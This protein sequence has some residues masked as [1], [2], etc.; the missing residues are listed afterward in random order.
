M[1]RRFGE[2]SRAVALGQGGA[3]GNRRGGHGWLVMS[4]NKW[5]AKFRGALHD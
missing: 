4:G 1:R 5:L 3:G 2:C